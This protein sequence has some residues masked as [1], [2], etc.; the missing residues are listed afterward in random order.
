M[1]GDEW[2]KQIVRWQDRWQKRPKLWQIWEFIRRRKQT[3]WP[4][5]S[6]HC[7]CQQRCVCV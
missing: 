6:F 7:H 3:F 5:F 2:G 1:S 4:T